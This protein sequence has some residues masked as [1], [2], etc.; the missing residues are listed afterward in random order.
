MQINHA[1]EGGLYAELLQ[2]RSFDALAIANG[3]N[4]SQ[5]TTE[6]EASFPSQV[7]QFANFTVDPE[8]VKYTYVT[9]QKS[10]LDLMQTHP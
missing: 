9:G 5:A 3:F 7:P 6:M 10:K 1:G 4:S 8:S 2:D